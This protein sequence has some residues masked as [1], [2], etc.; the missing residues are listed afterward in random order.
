MSIVYEI[1]R[2][3]TMQ[4][5]SSQEF[6]RRSESD[7]SP[8]SDSSTREGSGSKHGKQEVEMRMALKRKREDEGEPSDDEQVEIIR[9][10]LQARGRSPEGSNPQAG[11]STIDKRN[12]EEGPPRKRREFEPRHQEASEMEGTHENPN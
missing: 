9:Q 5:P 3:T 7:K 4:G 1:R 8:R 11:P 2:S 12:R 6:S 10:Q